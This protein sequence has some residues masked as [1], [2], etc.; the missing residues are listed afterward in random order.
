MG[1]VVTLSVN[2]TNRK[3]ICRNHTAT[4]LLQRALREVL[5]AHVEQ[6]GSNV[7]ADRLRFDFSHFSAMTKDEIAQV[8]NL[9]NQAIVTAYPVVTNVMNV[10]DAKKTGAMALFG[11]KYGDTVRVVSVGDG[12]SVELCGGTHVPNTAEITAF[13]I[14]SESGIAAGVRRIEAITSVGLFD[15]YKHMEMLLA[16]AAKTA[17]SD[18]EALVGAST[19]SSFG[20][21]APAYFTTS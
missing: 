15:Y 6:H 12:H 14:I 8:E 2:E 3:L 4:H 16:E 5:G 13:K 19:S 7:T 21:C 11:E 20:N 1:D 17:K 10:E 9:V 18:P